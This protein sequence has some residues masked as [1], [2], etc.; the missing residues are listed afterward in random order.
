MKLIDWDNKCYHCGSDKHRRNECAAFKKMTGEANVG[1][2]LPFVRFKRLIWLLFL[3]L[4]RLNLSPGPPPGPVELF[5]DI[6]LTLVWSIHRKRK[7]LLVFRV[8]RGIKGYTKANQ[9]TTEGIWLEY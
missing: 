8:F 4:L 5:F 9:K 7:I 1:I 3:E 2:G 6:S